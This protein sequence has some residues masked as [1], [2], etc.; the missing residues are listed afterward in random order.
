VGMTYF[1]FVASSEETQDLFVK[2]VMPA[3]ANISG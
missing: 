3:F 2:E 1:I